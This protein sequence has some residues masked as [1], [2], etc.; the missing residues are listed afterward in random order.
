MIIY[1]ED[2]KIN[3]EFGGFY[4]IENLPTKK[5]KGS[6]IYVVYAGRNFLSGTC[7][8]RKILYIG[9][10][11]EIETRINERHEHYNDW[12]KYL[13]KNEFL[14]FSLANVNTNDRERAEAA[15]ICRHRDILPINKKGK[16]SFLFP[17][18]QIKITGRFKFLDKD[19]IVKNIEN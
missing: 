16:K 4:K 13:N 7:L 14:F 2:N 9:E 15:L 6:G 8:L 18:T 12:L 17:D 1:K 3:L 5:H 11:E 10:S 19:F